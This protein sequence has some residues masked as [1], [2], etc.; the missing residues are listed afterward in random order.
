MRE[1]RGSTAGERGAGIIHGHVVHRNKRLEGRIAA[2]EDIVEK[3]H[4][5]DELADAGADHGFLR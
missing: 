1:R 4:A 2:G 3:R 5:R